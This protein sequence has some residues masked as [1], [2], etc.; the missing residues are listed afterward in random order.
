[1]TKLGFQ[2]YSARNFQPF[3]EIFKKLS[4]AGYAEV[5]GLWRH[6]CQPRRSVAE[7]AAP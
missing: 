7:G 2:L 1:M 4:Y 6:L 3:S 5:E